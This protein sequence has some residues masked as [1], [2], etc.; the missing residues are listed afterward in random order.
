M[1]SQFGGISVLDD[2][3]SFLETEEE[4]LENSSDTAEEIHQY[5]G[6]CSSCVKP[7]G[8][9]SSAFA[10]TANGHKSCLVEII[11]V[12]HREFG[13][14]IEDI[15]AENGSS[16]AHLAASKGYQDCL[17]VLLDSCQELAHIRDN[18]GASPLHACS[19]N[20][21]IECLK[22]LLGER[23]DEMPCDVDGAA[24]IH[25][26]AAAGHLQCLQVLLE[27]YGPESDLKTSSGE[28]PGNKMY[29]NECLQILSENGSNG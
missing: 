5:G 12:N 25:F 3:N 9:A 4:R 1:S 15:L 19:Y 20:G 10:A 11:D 21:N 23:G 6:A 17:R 14:N 24:P 26:A 22:L 2:L 29:A 18:R 7:E 13:Y 16:L 27:A 8:F 28:T